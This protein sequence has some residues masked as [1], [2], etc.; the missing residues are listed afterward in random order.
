MSDQPARW[1][2][3]TLVASS[4]DGDRFRPESLMNSLL[5]LELSKKNHQRSLFQ[6]ARKAHGQEKQQIESQQTLTEAEKNRHN[7][8]HG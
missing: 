5:N 1:N 7:V 2:Y 3:K 4:R 8:G 6:Q